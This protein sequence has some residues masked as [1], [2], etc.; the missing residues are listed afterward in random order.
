[1]WFTHNNK[2]YYSN[3]INCHS[4]KRKEKNKDDYAFSTVM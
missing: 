4:K 1:M 2:Y 3:G